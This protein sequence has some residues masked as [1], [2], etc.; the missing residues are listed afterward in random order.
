MNLLLQTLHFP[1]TS[2]LYS[3]FSTSCFKC[4]LRGISRSARLSMAHAS[5]NTQTLGLIHL[6]F[7][8]N[9]FVGAQ[10]VEDCRPPNAVGNLQNH[11]VV[12]LSNPLPSHQAPF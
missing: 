3:P 10:L 12:I 1:F 5:V 9:G 6:H 2:P 7:S 4:Q 8:N 11:D